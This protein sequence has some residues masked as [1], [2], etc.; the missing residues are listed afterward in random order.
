[1]ARLLID[2]LVPGLGP[3]RVITST[4]C[5][6]R[7]G[8]L[9]VDVGWGT[10]APQEQTFDVALTLGA[11][12]GGIS[13]RWTFPM[14]PDW[15]TREWPAHAIAWGYYPLSVPSGVPTGTYALSLALIDSTTGEAQ[16]KTATV[17]TVE[18][19]DQ[20]CTFP[21]PSDVT[22]THALF[23]SKLR[24][25]G[26]EVKR[27]GDYLLVRLYWRSDQRMN[28]DYKVFVHVFDPETG[29]PVAQDDTRP[30]RGAYPT[31][32]WGP[33]EVVE[34]PI[35]ISLAEAPPGT[36]GLAVG[37][38]D[39]ATMERLPVVSDR[40]LHADGRL[41]LPGETVVIEAGGR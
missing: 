10:T 24:L 33:G 30:H 5:V 14:S 36:Y 6:S 2:E 11:D 3:V 7:G 21:T 27:E 17:G 22:E 20:F 25:L 32:L 13:E 12:E 8:A 19:V 31:N 35:P 40:G 4:A 1:M 23:D 28:V 29:R 38:Y 18:V 39:P 37:V 16:G 15:P 26:Y 9:E 34:D 41:E